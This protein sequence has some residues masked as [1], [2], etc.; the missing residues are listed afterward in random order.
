MALSMSTAGGPALGRGMQRRESNALGSDSIQVRRN[1]RICSG[2]LVKG[3]DRVGEVRNVNKVV[4][5]VSGF[6]GLTAEM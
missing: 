4:G 1:V 3:A 2:M 5:E 6:R